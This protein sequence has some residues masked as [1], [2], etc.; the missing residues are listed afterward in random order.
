MI[1]CGKH[2]EPSWW[3]QSASGC[4]MTHFRISLRSLIC[5]TIFGPVTFLQ[6]TTFDMSFNVWQQGVV[7]SKQNVTHPKSD[8]Y[9]IIHPAEFYYNKQRLQSNR[10]IH[11]SDAPHMKLEIKFNRANFLIMNSLNFINF[12]ILFSNVS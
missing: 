1:S 4:R 10:R 12:F 2:P 3:F 5:C 6:N 7:M 9:V 8:P 11:E